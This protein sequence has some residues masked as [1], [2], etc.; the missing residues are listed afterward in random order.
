MHQQDICRY[1][2]AVAIATLLPQPLQPLIRS[3]EGM[4]ALLMNFFFAT[5]GAAGALSLCAKAV[6][7]VT[8]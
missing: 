3:A 4:A 8:F 2:R 1:P 5:V 7:A 6:A